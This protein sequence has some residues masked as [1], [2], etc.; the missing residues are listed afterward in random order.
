MYMLVGMCQLCF[1][2]MLVCVL[3]WGYCGEYCPK[4][5][6]TDIQYIVWTIDSV[7]GVV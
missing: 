3:G 2:Y 1:M 6:S 7:K 4:D 5:I